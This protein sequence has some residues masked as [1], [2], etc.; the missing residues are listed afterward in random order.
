MQVGGDCA[1]I[2]DARHLHTVR[3]KTLCNISVIA[4]QIDPHP[5]G[6]AIISSPM[7]RTPGAM[8]RCINYS[9]FAEI[10]CGPVDFSENPVC[11][12]PAN[13]KASKDKNTAP[14]A[15]SIEEWPAG[16]TSA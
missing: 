13:A 12:T 5:G 8:R 10:P 3:I 11:S 7:Q 9:R 2:G 16:L 15:S 14:G 1:Q 6:G 4:S